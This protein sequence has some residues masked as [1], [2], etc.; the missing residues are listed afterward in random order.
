MILTYST[1]NSMEWFYNLFYLTL[2]CKNF[3]HHQWNLIY[4]HALVFPYPALEG[5]WHNCMFHVSAMLLVWE[6][7]N[8]VV[9]RSRGVLDRDACCRI[10]DI[11][12]NEVWTLGEW[13]STGNVVLVDPPIIRIKYR[14]R[15]QTAA[16]P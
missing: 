1:T 9:S 12:S 16:S 3:S 14:Q 7:R 10:A 8:K 6:N 11:V 5:I 15:L 4:Q 2:N 13:T